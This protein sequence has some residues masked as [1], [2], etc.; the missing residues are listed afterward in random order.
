MALGFGRKQAADE[1]V[2]SHGVVETRDPADETNAYDYDAEK[3][4]NAPRKGSRV[5]DP[6]V[7]DD[8]STVSVG[9]QMELEASN[10]IKYRTC[11]WQ[12]VS[13][14]IFLSCHSFPV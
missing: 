2:S 5:A 12:K 11:T 4:T 3:G 7:V 8:A 10:S 14:T 9:K 6:V 13:S 1:Q